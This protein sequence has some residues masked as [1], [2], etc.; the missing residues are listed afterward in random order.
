ML[1][2]RN[3]KNDIN[4]GK[5]EII[6]G[7]RSGFCYGVQ[8]AVDKANEEVSKAK[9]PIYCLGELVHNKTVKQDLENKGLIFVEGITEA[10]G[11]TI[12][13]AHGIAKEVY[14]DAKKLDIDLVDLTC[15]NVLKLHKIAKEYCENGYYI[16]LIGKKDH[17]EN[18]GTISFCGKNSNVISDLEEVDL[19]IKELEKTNIK[20]LLI[21]SQ[22]TFS[23]TKF[24]EITEKINNNISKDVELEIKNTI[25]LA[26]ELRQK[27]TEEISK[28]VDVMIVVG[29]KNS[30]N[31]TKLY[32]ICLKNCENV[33]HIED[34]KELDVE[35][36]SQYLKVGIVAGASTPEASIE[37][38]I[39]LL[40]NKEESL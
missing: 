32:E 1:E 15:P 20:K 31:T 19:A 37:K 12:I 30:S 17:P 2:R 7:K 9:E 24:D 5:M 3:F 6:L 4:R 11:K 27:E 29:G 33:I 40:K 23:L 22:T 36:I 39:N 26:T 21:L 28:Q 38:V 18:I 16:F 14:E 8:S 25:C 35:T 34:E 10:K 13:R